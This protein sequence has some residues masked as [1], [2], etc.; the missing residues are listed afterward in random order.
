MLVL[1][2][3]GE[4]LLFWLHEDFLED[5]LVLL[6]A[7]GGESAVRSGGLLGV[8]EAHGVGHDR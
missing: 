1:F 7:L 4:L 3:L 8:G 5:Q 6:L 2:E